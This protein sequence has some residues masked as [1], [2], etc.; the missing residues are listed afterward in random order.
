MSP[1][2]LWKRALAV[3]FLL[4]TSAAYANP[5]EPLNT[6]VQQAVPV[7]MRADANRLKSNAT[8]I[9]AV[10]GTTVYLDNSTGCFLYHEK[11]QWRLNACYR[12]A[13][14]RLHNDAPAASAGH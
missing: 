4:G 8:Y 6:P 9:G 14:S 13:V 12:L 5:F 10:N 1:L 11:S 2:D 3:C 7:P